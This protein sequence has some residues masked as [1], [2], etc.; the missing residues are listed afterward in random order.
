MQADIV[1][2]VTAPPEIG[3]WIERVEAFMILDSGPEAMLLYEATQMAFGQSLG[4]GKDNSGT[5]VPTIETAA[6][7]AALRAMDW[8]GYWEGEER[9][10]LYWE[11]FN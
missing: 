1:A 9:A 6:R 2:N 4:S 3:S 7:G 10:R 5:C 11:R 8:V